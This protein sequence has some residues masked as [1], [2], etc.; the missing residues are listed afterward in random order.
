MITS[1]RCLER[2]SADGLAT[3]RSLVFADGQGRRSIY[4][5]PGVNEHWAAAVKIDG[6]GEALLKVLRRTTVVHL[7]SFTGLRELRLQEDL[8]NELDEEILVSFTPGAIYS[9]L[10][11]DRLAP[12]LRRT[13]MLFLYEQQLDTLLGYRTGDTFA[14]GLS[15]KTKL[16]TL[17][18]WKKRQGISQPTAVL[19]K[20]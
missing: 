17:F 19:V 5:F 15:A 2:L 12:I 20:K 13:N 18:Q 9:E 10:G 1:I 6:R 8:L 4:V 3:G 14:A 11:L 7:S 16:E